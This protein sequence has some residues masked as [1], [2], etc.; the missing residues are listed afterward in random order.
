MLGIWHHT[1]EMS[2]YT[3]NL[4]RLLVWL[5]LA[6]TGCAATV[7]VA[8]QP[9]AP[10]Q[11]AG[12]S[13]PD[14]QSA[15]P[16]Y[17]QS[18]SAHFVDWLSD[19][20]LLIST[21]FGETEQIHRVRAPLS[22]REQ[23]SFAAGGVIAGEA[24]PYASD[25]LAYLQT[26][27]GGQNT[28]LLLQHLDN[29]ELTS[30]TDGDHR[31]GPPLWAHDGKHL[32]FQSNRV[33]GTDVEIYE[34]DTDSPAAVP[35]L[36]TGGA[37][38]RWQVYDWS[39]DDKRLLLGREPSTGND[40][41]MQLFIVE[42]DSGEINPVAASS[43]SGR[44]AASV[45]LHARDA[46][47]ATD[48]HGIVLLTNQPPAAAG[49]S[50]ASSSRFVRLVYVDPRSQEWRN[51]GGNSNFDVERFD[52]SADGRYVAYTRNERGTDRLML[53]DQTRK[54]DLALTQLP[55]GVIGRFKFDQNS[56]RLGLSIESV[57]SPA[58]VY[59]L[60]LET[61]ALTAWTQSESG[62]VNTQSFA[63]PQTLSFPTWDRTDNGRQR[64]LAAWVYRAAGRVGVNTPRA[65]LILLCSGGAW[66]SRPRFDPF[67][68]FLV[69]ELG[70]VV[71]APSVRGSDGAGGSLEQAGAEELREDAVRDVGSLL[72]WIGL[73]RG[74]DRDRVAL[75]GE[76]FG[77]YLALQS[78]ADY[79]DRLRGGVAAFAPHGSALGHSS[80]I[81]RPVLLVQG[82]NNPTAPAYELSQLGMRLRADGVDVQTVEAG[83]EG[84]TFTHKSNRD[85]YLEAAAGFLAQILR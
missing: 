14:T 80:A 2:H 47:F 36:L 55:V 78:L 35:R 19:G 26:S 48:G 79:G 31:D 49:G 6:S 62:P 3:C 37:G 83:N 65:V 33:N 76:G 51:L 11:R 59:V 5:L 58:D 21:R 32:A 72:V 44:N 24:R 69:N 52:Q 74:L 39:G 61:H 40:A 16:R 15:L 54:L 27:H 57:R 29:H 42:A 45:P 84:Q 18:R 50:A 12:V 81:R 77:G 43:G 73:Q 75:L 82:L 41:E 17:L 22:M 10:L 20:S 71:V 56:Q 53:I 13:E 63:L 46:R 68:Q 34:L 23:V 66:Q 8:Q 9:P 67:L 60:E 64:E 85:A 28:Q 4:R 38:Y 7:T 25:A 70:F 1:N 30:L